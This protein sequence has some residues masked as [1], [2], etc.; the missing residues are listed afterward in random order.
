MCVRLRALWQGKY[1]DVIRR[2]QVIDQ[3][4]N[5]VMMRKV[6]FVTVL[7]AILSGAYADLNAQVKTVKPVQ[8]MVDGALDNALKSHSLNPV[9]AV[10][11]TFAKKNSGIWTY[12]KAYTQMCKSIYYNTQKQTEK[13]KEALS[14][15]ITLLEENDEKNTEDYA[16]LA[17]MQSQYIQYTSGME[18]ALLSMKCKRNAGKA[19]E[20][21]PKNTRAWAVLGII[22]Y[23]T[24]KI[25][26]GK[27]K[28]E[29]YLKKAISLPA[30]TVKNPYRPSWGRVEA[31]SLLL[32]YY[33][34]SGK[35]DSL[36][37]YYRKA[38]KEF[39]D[40]RAI[41]QYAVR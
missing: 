9:L 39:P 24:P 35:E 16:L 40:E 4:I 14:A 28:C 19:K 38:I 20:Q 8:E 10:E 17:Y 30:Q 27:A 31:Y 25:F 37:E 32:A 15:G 3:F 13:A 23:Y 21:D 22:D 5:D 29:E 2:T 33:K 18:S 12:W 26:G 36:R 6:F 34:E 7:L 41:R 1:R 11:K